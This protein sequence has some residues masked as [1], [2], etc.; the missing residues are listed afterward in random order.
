MTRMGIYLNEKQKKKGGTKMFKEKITM[1]MA[2]IVGITL[3]VRIEA[4]AVSVQNVVKTEPA[5]VETEEM[6]RNKNE[7]KLSLYGYQVDPLKEEEGEFDYYIFRL[8]VN[9]E[10]NSFYR[11]IGGRGWLLTNWGNE[12][13]E[14][15]STVRVLAEVRQGE[16][17]SDESAP[18]P[19]RYLESKEKQTFIFSQNV[20]LRETMARVEWTQENPPWISEQK[21][22]TS[23]KV[24]WKASID[25]DGIIDNPE[26]EKSQ[27]WG[28]SFVVRTKEGASP[29]VRVS[30]EAGYWFDW[31]WPRS[32]EI[33]V[34]KL[35]TDW[36]KF[37]GRYPIKLRILGLAGSFSTRL[38]LDKRLTGSLS[39]DSSYQTSF[40]HGSS[41]LFEVDRFVPDEAGREGARYHCEDNSQTVRQR[42]ELLFHYQLE[43]YLTILSDFGEAEGEG[44]YVAGDKAV[45]KLKQKRI[46]DYVFQGW[47]KDASGTGLE[48]KPIYMNRAK[49]ARA[50]WRKE[51]VKV[52]K[53]PPFLEH[54]A[55]E[56]QK[57]EPTKESRTERTDIGS[58]TEE[59]SKEDTPT[60][61]KE[62]EIL[63]WLVM[64]CIFAVCASLD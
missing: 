32:N 33:E 41:H 61:E 35:A 7:V 58:K 38:Y 52:E 64:L 25:T 54:P 47:S 63:F 23:E 16:I 37:R 28:F 56:R 6:S 4:Q 30:L 20:N 19:G 18:Q 31:Q 21:R 43:H 49:I 29:E 40:P 34:V 22:L 8:K 48:S 44:W 10:P 24:L 53:S 1:L 46:G 2:L 50:E 60:R 45:A 13:D 15:P 14:L 57:E 39:E 42:G 9:L 17:D 12:D 3:A 11:R 51:I 55:K 5:K 62:D 27:T 36:L 26:A 59:K